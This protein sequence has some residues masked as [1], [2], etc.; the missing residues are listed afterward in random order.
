M[1]RLIDDN[2]ILRLFLSD[3]KPY[4][5]IHRFVIIWIIF[6]LTTILV[7]DIEGTLD[8]GKDNKGFFQHHA[9]Q[10][11][12]AFYLIVFFLFPYV[13]GKF[14]DF[15]ENLQLIYNPNKT[16]TKA[17]DDIQHY[18]QKI[19]NDKKINKIMLILFMLI[20]LFNGL[21]TSIFRNT[22]KF[23]FFDSSDYIL[24]Y[25]IW[26]IQWIFFFGILTSQLF[27][28]IFKM[29]ISVGKLFTYMIENGKITLIP[30]FPDGAGGLGY[31][32]KF[33]LS[34]NLYLVPMAI[35][36][37]LYFVETEVTVSNI[38][39]LCSAL[40]CIN[41]VFFA[42]LLPAHRLMRETKERRL[43]ELGREYKN[44]YYLL[45]EKYD[46]KQ[47]LDTEDQEIIENLTNIEFFY[48]RTERMPVW[49]FDL[50][51]IIRFTGTIVLPIVLIYIELVIPMV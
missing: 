14:R 20:V 37:V 13:L 24:G 5:K 11:K 19:H 30:I 15:T 10:G 3:E 1:L 43:E 50:T 2:P 29:I 16:T 27:A 45:L 49:P 26:R 46:D 35:V 4:H 38:G 51:T 34:L 44:Q 32:G 8:L 36:V 48:E 22:Y 40:F 21:M 9:D 12:Y 33:A 39:L 6:L 42:P 23:D 41:I 25:I 47:R 18:I 7:C 17:S 31:L 28:E